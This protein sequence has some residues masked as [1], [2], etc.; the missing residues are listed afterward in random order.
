MGKKIIYVLALFLWGNLFSSAAAETFFG[1][2]SFSAAYENWLTGVYYHSSVQLINGSYHNHD[3]R[4]II[5]K[6]Q[7][8]T[9]RTGLVLF[10]NSVVPLALFFKSDSDVIEVNVKLDWLN[11]LF[12][13]FN[14]DENAELSVEIS[15]S[16]VEKP[17]IVKFIAVPDTIESGDSLD[18]EWE[19][20]NADTVFIDNG[21][22]Q[23]ADS[24]SL[25]VAPIESLLYTL[26]AS[27]GGDTATANVSVSVTIPQ[28]A[29]SLDVSPAS[30]IR[31]E[32][33][34]LT[35]ESENAASCSIE[36]DIGP[37]DLAGTL[38]VAPEFTTT[39]TVTA[40][41]LNGELVMDN[42]T[43]T[44]AGPPVINV[45][46][47]LISILQGETAQLS[48]SVENADE[49]YI[50]RGIGIVDLSGSAS[51]IPEHTTTYTIIGK[52]GYGAAS[53]KIK[54]KVTGSPL[55]LA[56]GS[57]GDHYKDL[58]PEDATIEEYDNK[59]FSIM[60]G[61]I[62]D[63]RAAPL[64]G[65]AVTVLNHPEYGTAETDNEGNFAIPVEGGGNLMATFEK[66]GFITAQRRI[67]VPW[68]D[69]GVVDT[70][71]LIEEDTA[72]TSIQ[73]DGNADSI[74]THRS[75]PV[76][77]ER[78]TRA[79]TLIF[80][81]DNRAYVTDEG[82]ND[83][84]ELETVNVRVSEYQTPE[85]MPA[86]LPPASA[87][88]YCAEFTV[89]GVKRVRFETP[90]VA[91][92]DNFLGFEV[93]DIV[94]VGAYDRDKGIW[95][96]KNNARVVK[97]LDTDSDGVADAMDMTGDDMADDI[98]GDGTTADETLGLSD[99]SVYEPG[100]T[101][102]RFELDHFSPWDCNDPF[103]FPSDAKQPELSRQPFV[104]RQLGQTR[105]CSVSYNSHV[106]ERSR[107]F[108]E[109]IPVP[110]TDF[111]LHY[112]SDN[113]VQNSTKI[114]IPL[115]GDN[116]PDSLQK[117]ELEI[118]LAGKMY[119]YSFDPLPNQDYLFNWDGLD[120]RGEFV[121]SRKWAQIKVKYRYEGWYGS[122]YTDWVNWF[123]KYPEQ[124]TSIN[125]TSCKSQNFI[126]SIDPSSS[127][128]DTGY[129]LAEGWTISN[130]HHLS[131]LDTGILFRGD[132]K[133][134]SAFNSDYKYGHLGTANSITPFA[135]AGES[136][137]GGDN[138][139]AVDALIA[140]PEEIA[141]DGEGNLYIADS[142]NFRVRK[143]DPEGIITTVAGTGEWGAY[144][145]PSDGEFVASETAIKTP[146][147]LTIDNSGNVYFLGLGTDMGDGILY[148]IDKKGMLSVP[149]AEDENGNQIRLYFPKGISVDNNGSLYIADSQNHVIRM[150]DTGG[151]A[152]TIAGTGQSGYAGDN[153]RCYDAQL[154]YP[155]DVKLDAQGNLYIA[156]WG[157]HVVRKIA[158]D[159]VIT[160]IAGTK[161]LGYS[162]DGG[163]AV[164]AKLNRPSKLEV[165]P[166]GNLY[167]V[168]S[169]NRC[170][171]KVSGDGIITTISGPGIHS[172]FD[173][174]LPVAPALLTEYSEYADIAMDDS[175]VIYALF[176]SNNFIGRI[177]P[178]TPVRFWEIE[179]NLVYAEE[180]GLGHVIDEL[181]RHLRTIDLET[182]ISINEF[183]FS[184]AFDGAL[185]AI[186]DRFGNVSQIERNELGL[187]V[188]VVSQDGLRTDLT[189]GEDNHLTRI[190]FS[191]GNHYDF[192][193]SD[194]G[195]M[196][197]ETDPGGNR[198]IHG[199]SYSDKLTD[200][201]DENNGHWKYQ[202][203]HL[204][205]GAIETIVTSAQGNQRIYLDKTDPAGGYTSVITDQ[206]GS[207][208]VF[209]EYGMTALKTTSCGLEL[210][211]EYGTDP[212]FRYK[213]PST[214]I[215]R[216][217]A[218]LEKRISTEKT[219][220][221]PSG[222][223]IGSSDYNIDERIDTNG[224]ISTIHHD[225]F[226]KK[227]FTSPE[228]RSVTGVYDPATL[229]TTKVRISGLL[230]TDFTYDSQGRLLT[231]TTG[232]RII[233]YQYNSQGFLKKVIDPDQNETVYSHDALGRV[234]QAHRP[235]NSDLYFSYD[236]N[237]NMTVLT[238]PVPADHG[239]SY[240]KV[241]LNT[242]YIPPL[243]G[244]YSFSFDADRRQTIMTFP[245][246][247]TLITVYETGVN[248]IEHIMTPDGPIEFDYI[249]GSKV[250]AVTKGGEAISYTYDANLVTG[251]N[252]AGTINQS[253][254]YTY[255][256]D[257]NLEN[258]TYAGGSAAYTYDNDGLLTK[259]GPFSITRDM[260]NGLALAVSDGNLDVSRSFNGYAEMDSQV[261]SVGR[262]DLVLW[263]L[264]RDAKGKITRKTETAEG[265]TSVYNYTYD[266]MGRLISVIK[267]GTLSEQYQ[268]NA[269][270]SRSYEMNT[271][272]WSVEAPVERSFTY[273]EDDRLLTAGSIEFQYNV[274]GFLTQKKIDD[275]TRTTYEY[276]LKGE[277]KKV[278]LP[279]TKVI[280]YIHDPLGRRI[281]KI[282]DD[283]IV[284]KYLWQGR[285]R[286]LAI[287]DPSDNLVMRFNYADDRM[288]L[289]M[290][291]QGATYYLA[292]DQV[293]SL[294]I[295]AD[296]SGNV[297]KSV[298]YDS[299]GNV[300]D[301]SAPAIQ[302]PFGFA[303]GFY[304]T[305]TGLVRFGFRD[306]DP[307]TGRWTAKDPVLF[308]GGDTDLYGYC[309][310]DPVNFVDPTGQ[311][312]MAG[313]IV[314]VAAGAYGG[315][316]GGMVN[317]N[318]ATGIISGVGGAVAGGVV[319]IVAPHLSIVTGS[320]VGGIVGGSA[321]G[322]IGVYKDKPCARFVD[323]ANAAIF[324]GFAGGVSGAIG[325]VFT[326]G[327]QASVA[328][329]VV[330]AMVTAPIGIG[331]GLGVS[332]I[333]K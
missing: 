14:G 313:F 291:K 330:S 61:C 285:T 32:N 195:L 241:N 224:K 175:G 280:E 4:M 184:D 87:F 43:V 73:F 170:V 326:A 182:G 16:T 197:I 31:G 96:P 250:G 312:G 167:I 119:N 292:Y 15:D 161:E 116:L 196:E 239:F 205:D 255:D 310:D 64:E 24:G 128:Y 133:K 12:V 28:P 120:F 63:T 199:F 44:V 113:L 168:D 147:C 97:L 282:V 60:T 164:E 150:V 47:E 85:S 103:N 213:Y 229:L 204:T 35:W 109:T 219:Y 52:N 160:T 206:E 111:S 328:L 13:Y 240:N 88:T 297:V 261:R 36:P 316:I 314:G 62:T 82:G 181:G 21:V 210:D 268:Y 162:G 102:W 305:D 194:G 274:D 296:A 115:T 158:V 228:G 319:G 38:T 322:L 272:K 214:I 252:L 104:D 142:W 237:G 45:A 230:D 33:T 155:T 188:A 105:D 121:R 189:I 190:A 34:I 169:G 49:V 191:D 201:K 89:D 6:Q 68:N 232:D 145:T 177:G 50:D 86:A 107:V 264:I 131:P 242:E 40:L 246:G 277:L 139:A 173:E 215:A 271:L 5:R 80:R 156:D 46:P 306:Y 225:V 209:S 220:T 130:H 98:S 55:D 11:F 37:V 92:V 276:S 315:F 132:G 249:C 231:L 299:F 137:Y 226:S 176:A 185:V 279:D 302:V 256:H 51:V 48:W 140:S 138:G 179:S 320:I 106:D 267:D 293:G 76:T 283:Q 75:T 244:S 30:I 236:A 143:V 99:A 54:V 20:Q 317:G 311:F 108:H 208:T 331:F 71:Q 318:I 146:S 203:R 307:D 218:G 77:T 227:I 171:R 216:T 81:G 26:T 281:A 254:A 122:S 303:G 59:R 304:D 266:T 166:E 198:F 269:N 10:N 100:N 18:L 65:V 234:I 295:V 39:Y 90:A 273:S 78:G 183:E 57:F 163:P 253:L 83:V 333:T 153:G 238:T 93:G 308:F 118:R 223:G 152:V 233:Q 332:A 70:V 247:E 290:E 172:D 235:D 41:G 112:S 84:M 74:M 127:H 323:Y 186:T 91:L 212:E 110:G 94:P 53:G 9:Y 144:L 263:Q 149:R 126:I 321:G 243:S 260:D 192:T 125:T 309:L 248:R 288:P 151:K 159:G 27:G 2:Q 325:G 19:V 7:G 154:H 258:F 134:I 3:A 124:R 300:I 217:P 278:T 251:E 23:V 180:N 298:E 22:G 245:S 56:K 157:N 262:R 148:K 289:S 72:S 114:L 270:G 329:D 1:P 101:Y 222:Q 25:R 187:P 69:F 301:D 265:N 324:G 259:A 207:Q 29:V 221:R 67:Y 193:Y 284:E 8:D 200:V 287:Y 174:E 58:I 117:V 135:G 327:A 165:D 275:Q 286:L 79:M 202:Q 136:G 129:N 211:F 257:F 294:R 178:L 66:Q 17:K 123:A 95:I 141:M 42:A